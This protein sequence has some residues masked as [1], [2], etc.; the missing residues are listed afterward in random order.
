MINLKATEISPDSKADKTKTDDK[1]PAAKKPAAKKAADNKPEAAAKKP[2]ETAKKPTP[3]KPAEKPKHKPGEKPAA[4][5][6]KS[7]KGLVLVSLA[8]LI[9][10]GLA[11]AFAYQQYGAKFWPPAGS[12]SQQS[13]TEL[14][15][16]L[17]KLEAANPP[18]PQLPADVKSTIEKL[19]TSV[20]QLQ[21]TAK[22]PSPDLGKEVRTMAA[23]LSEA[24]NTINSL[25]ADIGKTKA[26]ISGA[27]ARGGDAATAAFAMK[28]QQLGDQ[29]KAI[30][31]KTAA[32]EKRLASMQAQIKTQNETIASLANDKTA[33][34][35]G[36]V[37]ELQTKIN[38][39][40]VRLK[41]A[42]TTSQTLVSDMAGVKELQSKLVAAGGNSPGEEL[43]RNYTVLRARINSGVP[44]EAE[45]DNVSKLIPQ[46]ATLDKLRKY[47]AKGIITSSELAASLSKLP[48]T[49]TAPAD[50]NT[51]K[52]EDGG[53]WGVLGSK[54][55]SMAKISKVGETDWSSVMAKALEAARD[56]R[57]ASAA[58]ILKQAKGPKPAGL[59]KWLET[60][61]P[62]IEADNAL[63]TI[64]QTVMQA[65]TA[66]RS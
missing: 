25:K 63:K 48:T 19:S 50:N 41:E 14:A 27:I 37:A 5:P 49:A 15:S 58:K 36:T 3:A 56:G 60:A 17:E 59:D 46:E 66:E 13:F 40:T 51:D 30:A 34:L 7:R 33:A 18:A 53:V 43:A 12:V 20:S 9:A 32:M 47:A 54:L 28:T 52:A 42:E 65:I 8:A 61:A 11:G 64:S 21:K 29:V 24:Q 6:S 26:T 39:L 55:S 44:F 16:R 4:K 57:I 62:R 38:S 1:K 31:D 10:A 22:I 2:S 23:R 45:L 35:E